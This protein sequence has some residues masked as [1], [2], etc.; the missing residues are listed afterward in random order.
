MLGLSFQ[1]L[2]GY[3]N[4]QV[5]FSNRWTNNQVLCQQIQSNWPSLRCCLWSRVWGVGVWGGGEGVEAGYW[6]VRD[7]DGLP[8]FLKQDQ[9]QHPAPSFHFYLFICYLFLLFNKI[10]LVNLPWD[11][12]LKGS[13]IKD[14]IH[15]QA[16]HKELCHRWVSV[17]PKLSLANEAGSLGDL[18]CSATSATDGDI[19]NHSKA[20]IGPNCSHITNKSRLALPN[21]DYCREASTKYISPSRIDCLRFNHLVA[22]FSLHPGANNIRQFQWRFQKRES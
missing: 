2:P 8:H 21:W 14:W 13:T 22:C 5:W 10:S 17:F 3:A 15:I 7:G 18:W 1:V 9:C 4:V 16:E 11:R 20:P 6:R 12:K 19:S